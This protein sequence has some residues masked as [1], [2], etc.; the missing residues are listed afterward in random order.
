VLVTG[1]CFAWRGRRQL[2]PTKP[3]RRSSLHDRRRAGPPHATAL[4]SLFRGSRGRGFKSA[5]PTQVRGLIRND[6]RSSGT[7]L[8]TKHRAYFAA[9][10]I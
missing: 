3:P 10:A 1:S 9:G 4:T 8:G 6:D 2:K 7:I 5:I